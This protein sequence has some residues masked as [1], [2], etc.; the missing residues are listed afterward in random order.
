VKKLEEM[1]PVWRFGRRLEENIKMC[2]EEIELGEVD[3]IDL[4]QEKDKWLVVVKSV[5]N[6]WI[7]KLGEGE[8]RSIYQLTKYYCFQKH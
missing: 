4:A 2:L 6:F 1:R 3:W 7:P 5:M 8:G